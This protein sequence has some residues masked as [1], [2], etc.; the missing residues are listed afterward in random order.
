[1]AM[2]CLSTIPSTAKLS[3][4]VFRETWTDICN[5]DHERRSIEVR[6][7]YHH[8]TPGK[9]EPKDDEPNHRSNWISA[10]GLEVSIG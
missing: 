6:I 5:L 9:H 1:M 4:Y 8:I 7:T 3:A 10:A 2:C